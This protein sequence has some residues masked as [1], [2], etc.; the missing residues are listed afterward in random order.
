MREQKY[1][2]LWQSV[3][4]RAAMRQELSHYNTQPF[5][6]LKHHGWIVIESSGNPSNVKSLSGWRNRTEFVMDL[7]NTRPCFYCDIDWHRGF[8][9]T[10]SG[11]L[12]SYETELNEV[13]MRLCFR[14]HYILKPDLSRQLKPLGM[15]VHWNLLW[16]IDTL[17]CG[18]VDDFH[19]WERTSIR[20]KHQSI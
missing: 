11:L 6:S 15:V 7:W 14:W 18:Q 16:R 8:Y 4:C 20:S 3:L 9:V 12:R 10:C 13:V 19:P 5:I 1:P 2:R 17:P